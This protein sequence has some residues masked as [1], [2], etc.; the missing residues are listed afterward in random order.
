MFLSFKTPASAFGLDLS[1]SAV[2]IAQLRRAGRNFVIESLIEMP[3]P[4]GLVKE[5]EAQNIDEFSQPL[6]KLLAPHRK[7]LA[8]G[9]I[10]SLPESKT[11][12]QTILIAKHEGRTF[13]QQLEE[14]L[15]AYLPLP[16]EEMYQDSAIIGETDKE[17]RVITGAAPKTR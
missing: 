11:F 16:L 5:G 12:I 7:E 14:A 13:I 8:D 4:E 3:I 1:D 15:P 10:V 6:I 9:V 17:W 2:K